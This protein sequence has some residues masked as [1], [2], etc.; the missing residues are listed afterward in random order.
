MNTWI[1]LIRGI[2][3]GGNNIIPMQDLRDRLGASGYVNVRTYIQSGNI[4]LDTQETAAA[5]ICNHV[6]ARNEQPRPKGRG[7][8]LFFI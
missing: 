6:T 1:L 5:A 3:V 8:K 7:I 2:N 4:I